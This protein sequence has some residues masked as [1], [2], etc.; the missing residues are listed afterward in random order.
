VTTDTIPF[1]VGSDTSEE[2]AHMKRSTKRSDEQQVLGLIGS[3]G[4]HGATDDEIEATLGM[5]HQNASAR[6]NGL[7]QK[8]LVKDSG[9]QRKTRSGRNATVW[10]LGKG[11]P[12]IGA[13][14]NRVARPGDD[15]LTRAAALLHVADA[16]N[17]DGHRRVAAWLFSL[18]KTVSS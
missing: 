9:M 5:R 2:A 11:D 7:V 14:N 18:V 12:L 6:R 8:G 13:K 3:R 4:D 1:V 17:I 16:I 10:V 15:D